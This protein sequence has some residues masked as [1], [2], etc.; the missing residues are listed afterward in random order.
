VK[1]TQNK[2]IRVGLATSGRFHLLELARELDE[3]GLDVRFYSYVP[4]RRAMS[5]GLPARCHVPLL[6]LIF[7]LVLW[8]RL[9]PTF[10][11]RLIERLLNWALDAAMILMMRQC[12]VFVCMSGMYVRALRVAKRRYGAKLVVHRAS[13]HVLAQRALLANVRSAAPTTD[14]MVQRELIGYQLADEIA[15]PS[16]HVAESFQPWP[17]QS[18]KVHRNPYGVD[19]AQFPMREVAHLPRPPTILFVGHWSYRKGADLL[20][21]AVDELECEVRLVHV[22]AVLDA[23]LPRSP[24]FEHHEPVPQ[25]E[26]VKFYHAADVFVLPSREDGFGY[27]LAQALSCGLPVICTDKTGGPDLAQLPGLARLI[28]IVPAGSVEALSGALA[29]V[30]QQLH[31]PVAVKPITEA[32][33]QQ[34]SW[35]HYAERELK[36]LETLLA[37][38][39]SSVHHDELTV[40]S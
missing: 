36:A 8:E 11:P 39:M 38:E 12:D 17:E 5:F 25:T 4:K 15:V 1:S 34:L 26:L 13:Q 27:V 35:S 40:A 30:L 33:R 16:A 37:H 20:A 9:W 7:P 32:E 2:R 31:G 19:A 29:A 14:F 3:L 24:R 23:P 6:P 10:Q 21:K 28:R 18:R 22:G